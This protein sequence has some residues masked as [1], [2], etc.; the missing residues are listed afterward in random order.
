[1][2]GMSTETTIEART[3]FQQKAEE[4]ELREAELEREA[5]EAERQLQLRLGRVNVVPLPRVATQPFRTELTVERNSLFVASTFKGDHFVRESV[6]KHPESGEEVIR[7]VT[8][9]K[10][11]EKGKARGVLTQAH[12]DVFY[13]LLQI[14]GE[15]GNPV[16]EISGSPHGVVSASGYELVT[17]VCA[18]DDSSKAYQR[19]RDLVRD[20]A[21]VPVLLENHYTWQGLVDREEFTL[22]DRVHWRER[23]VD[24]DTGRPSRK[25]RSEVKIHLSPNVTTGFLDK[26]IKVLLA[27]PYQALRDGGK[28]RGEIACLLYPWLDLQLSRRESYA[29][30]LENLTTRFGL[31][32]CR[33]KSKR[34]EK[35][36]HAVKALDGQLIQQGRY[37]LRIAVTESADGLDFVLTARR[38][39]V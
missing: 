26:N 15:A 14:W 1:M 38:E 28:R 10:T 33:F 11:G 2:A 16:V 32:P 34:K 30:K 5:R 3:V 29:A 23:G 13:V 18:G 39:P 8:V 36:A 24:R 25:G 17:R 9:G 7:R 21:A 12:Q 19:T 37:R 27:G 4:M 35:F 31:T 6:V 22:L 20:L